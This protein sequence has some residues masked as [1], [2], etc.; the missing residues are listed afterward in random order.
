ML[1]LS[2]VAEHIGRVLLL[3]VGNG[4][5]PYVVPELL[6]VGAVGPLDLAVLRWLPWIDEEVE[7]VVPFAREVERVKPRRQ[8][9]GAL[10][11]SRV[12]VCEDAAV[13][14]LDAKN[15]ERCF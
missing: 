11:I 5:E 1:A 9:I 3:E 12:V 13:V 2:I 10:P 14:R 4:V 8:R 6:A 7:D 15:L